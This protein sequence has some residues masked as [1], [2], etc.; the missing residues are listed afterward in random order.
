VTVSAYPGEEF[1]GRVD[2]ISDAIDPATRT[3]KLRVRVPNPKSRLK[4]EMFASISVGVG[5]TERV[6]MLPSRA[7]FIESGRTWVYV[8]LGRGQFVRRPVELGLEEGM[9]RRIL[10]GLKAGDRIVVDGALL[11]RQEEEKRAS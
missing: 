1:Q 7:A 3:A 4:P 10:S 5:E 6:L 2:Y 9:D 11:L 8:A